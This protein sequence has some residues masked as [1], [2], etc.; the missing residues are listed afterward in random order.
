MKYYLYLKDQPWIAHALSAIIAIAI[1]ILSLTPLERL[2][3]APGGDKLHHLIAYAALAFPTALIGARHLL[4]LSLCYI[5]LGAG[6]EVIQP[7]V[8]R[9]GEWLDMAANGLGVLIGT[10]CGMACGALIQARLRTSC[11]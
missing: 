7:Y 11:K 4:F 5:G 2:P 6:I 9:Y 8:N 3:D 1:I 10:A